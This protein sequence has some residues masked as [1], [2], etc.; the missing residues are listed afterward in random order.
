MTQRRP[1]VW[2]SSRPRKRPDPLEFKEVTSQQETA[3]SSYGDGGFRIGEQRSKGSI[4]ITPKGYYPWDAVE[5]ASATLDNLKLIMDQSADIDILLVG[6]G[7]NMRPLNKPLRTSLEAAGI[8][9]D[10]MATGA[11][12]RTYNI[13]LAE[14][15]KVAAALIAID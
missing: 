8:A 9:V 1:R 3:I 13:L 12:A 2:K 6:T 14:G 15:R 7:D 5:M 10:I 11:A 4:L